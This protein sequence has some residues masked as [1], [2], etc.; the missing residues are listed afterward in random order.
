MTRPYEKT[1]TTCGERPVSG[2]HSHWLMLLPLFPWIG[3]DIFQRRCADCSGGLT[4]LALAA[5]A[6]ILVVA[7]VV[8]V[9]LLAG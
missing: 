3:A 8:A 9:I 5:W 4:L 6:V 7:F 1:C 2:R